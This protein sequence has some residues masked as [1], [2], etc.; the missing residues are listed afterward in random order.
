M[1]HGII[2]PFI[3]V[4]IVIII[5]FKLYYGITHLIVYPGTTLG[6]SQNYAVWFII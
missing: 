4:F 5:F 6:R 2:F 3:H 1:F